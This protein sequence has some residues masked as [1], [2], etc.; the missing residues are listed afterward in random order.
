MYVGQVC[1]YLRPDLRYQVSE[2]SPPGSV[3]EDADNRINT[4]LS[5]ERRWVWEA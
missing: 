5:A 1:S 4:V 2:A 3:G